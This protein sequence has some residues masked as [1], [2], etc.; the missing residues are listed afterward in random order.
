MKKIIAIS[1][2]FILAIANRTFA[3][4]GSNSPVKNPMTICD[5]DTTKPSG[6]GHEGSKGW[7]ELP[8]S[9]WGATIP[10][11]LH[12]LTVPRDGG[13]LQFQKTGSRIS[14]VKHTEKNTTRVR[15]FTSVQYPYELT[16]PAPPVEGGYFVSSDKKYAVCFSMVS[17]TYK[18]YLHRAAD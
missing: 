10:D 17:N 15:I 8:S 6:G 9:G 14:N 18:V 1:A 16:P 4:T 5:P 11:G 12:N 2:V 13:T 7:I 3:G